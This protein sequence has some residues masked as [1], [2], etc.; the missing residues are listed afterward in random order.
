MERFRDEQF[1][2][3]RTVS[4]GGIDKVH[5]EL[6]RPTQN[7]QRILSIS[8]PTPYSLARQAHRAKAKS[9]HRK[10]AAQK[11]RRFSSWTRRRRHKFL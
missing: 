1:A 11:K 4:I 9:I 6:D 2:H 3:F 10:I 5:A 7:F 8:R